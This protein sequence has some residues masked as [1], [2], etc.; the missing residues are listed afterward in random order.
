M[1][2]HER[3]NLS[4][5]PRKDSNLVGITHIFFMKIWQG[6]IRVGLPFRMSWRPGIHLF[7][8]FGFWLAFVK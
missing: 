3:N 1:Y 2:Y 8:Q 5:N 7:S 4:Y 6:E